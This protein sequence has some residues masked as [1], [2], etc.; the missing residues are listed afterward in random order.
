MSV[1]GGD[2][3]IDGCVCPS[4]CICP[5]SCCIDKTCTV[6][7]IVTSMKLLFFFFFFKKEISS[8]TVVFKAVEGVLSGKIRLYLLKLVN[9]YGNPTLSCV[10][11]IQIC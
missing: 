11:V 2:G 7:F 5:S 10:S 8:Q 9:A 3:F 4:S 1:P 6:L